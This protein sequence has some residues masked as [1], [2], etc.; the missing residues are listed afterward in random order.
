MFY[1]KH[2]LN[3]HLGSNT[4][5]KLNFN[6]CETKNY[7]NAYTMKFKFCIS[8]YFFQYL[9]ITEEFLENPVNSDMLLMLI[10][11]LVIMI[12]KYFSTF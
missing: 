3:V 12:P 1:K 4:F 6:Y 8:S 2:L 9:S 11:V 5:S 10:L 7:L